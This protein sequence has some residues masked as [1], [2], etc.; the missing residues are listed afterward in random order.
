MNKLMKKVK[1]INPK[2]I[3]IITLSVFLLLGFVLSSERKQVISEDVK[4]HT[5]D[6]KEI[7]VYEQSIIN[8]ADEKEQGPVSEGEPVISEDVQMHT[9]DGK[10]IPVYEQSIM[11]IVDEKELVP[12]SERKQVISKDIEMHTADGRVIPVYEMSEEEYE[13]TDFRKK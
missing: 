11:H 1:M 7:P 8:I 2:Y 4:V 10:E 12:V 6:D 3:I 9:A 5:A 13:K